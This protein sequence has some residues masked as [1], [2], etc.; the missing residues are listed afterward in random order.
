MRQPASTATPWHIKPWYLDLSA[1]QAEHIRQLGSQLQHAIDT[2]PP[3]WLVLDGWDGN[4][5]AG[6]LQALYP[7]WA[8]ERR[9]LPDPALRGLEGLAPCLLPLQTGPQHEPDVARRQNLM[10]DLLGLMWLDNQRRLVRQHVCGVVFIGTSV[11][12][13]FTQWLLLRHQRPNDGSGAFEFRHHDPRVLQRVWPNLGNAQ[14]EALLGPAHS[15][16]Q[17]G[18]T[19]GPWA[20]QDIAR[21][22]RQLVGHIGEWRVFDRAE[23]QAPPLPAHRL[24]NGLQR[25]LVS[26]APCGHQVWLTLALRGLAAC[27]QPTDL[28][29][30][31]LLR[32]AQDWGLQRGQQW[33]DW[34]LWTWLGTGDGTTGA[35]SYPRISWNTPAWQALAT[36]M[37]EL[38]RQQPTLGVPELVELS[39]ATEPL[40]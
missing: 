35:A 13:L 2:R 14:R 38:L 24:L 1:G 5:A 23:V 9:T 12:E 26:S 4:P 31:Q 37:K 11:E 28:E 21:H 36:R 3:A 39:Q 6:R 25:W 33:Q 27:E 8:A 7:A 32:Q 40:F 34:V 17:L 18:A 29:M 30:N 16:W 10:H 22:Q 20:P 15:L 19:W